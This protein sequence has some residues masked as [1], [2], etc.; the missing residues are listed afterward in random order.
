MSG[1][2][3][4]TSPTTLIVSF[5]KEGDHMPNLMND[6]FTT[7]NTYTQLQTLKKESDK[8]RDSIMDGFKS[9]SAKVSIFI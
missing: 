6:I 7:S 3:A 4:P 5:M 8:I 1:G 9:T 2:W